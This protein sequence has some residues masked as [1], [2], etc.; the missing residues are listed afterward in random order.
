MQLTIVSVSGSILP[1]CQPSVGLVIRDEETGENMISGMCSGKTLYN[2]VCHAFSRMLK[3]P[4]SIANMQL[5]QDNEGSG[6]LLC[7]TTI[8]FRG[9][10]LKGGCGSGKDFDKGDE[11]RIFVG[12]VVDALNTYLR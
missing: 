5:L 1:K 9:K 6:R 4:V 10:T 8:C 2:G 12:A 11:L 3:S 7:M